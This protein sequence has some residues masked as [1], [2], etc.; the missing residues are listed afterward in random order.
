MLHTYCQVFFLATAQAVNGNAHSLEL[1]ARNVVID[2]R[3]DRHDARFQLATRAH[4]ILRAHGLHGKA[5][6]HDLRRVAVAGRQIDQP[7]LRNDIDR[8][9]VRQ[10]VSINIVPRLID[11]IRAA[12]ERLHVDLDIEV[13]GVGD[14]RA[15]LHPLAVL[16]RN[17]VFAARDGHENVADGGGI[18]HR[19]DLVA[20]HNGL[21]RPD[22]VNFCHDDFRAEALGAQKCRMP[23]RKD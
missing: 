18:H 2:F 17:D 23:S 22:G 6:V 20:V 13:S 8:L 19:H 11:F 10:T 15:V 7:P 14:D 4:Q 5:H 16:E 21:E 3:G 12:V 9:A 1:A